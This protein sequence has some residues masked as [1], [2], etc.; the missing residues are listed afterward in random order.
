MIHSFVD[1]GQ[2]VLADMGFVNRLDARG[3][4]LVDGL[5]DLTSSFVGLV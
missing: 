2:A 3:R 4:L 5:S 1:V